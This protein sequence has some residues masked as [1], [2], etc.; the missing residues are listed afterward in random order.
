ME[1]VVFVRRRLSC[2]KAWLPQRPRR[3]LVRGGGGQKGMHL[4]V[5]LPPLLCACPLLGGRSLGFVPRS[6]GSV[7][8]CSLVTFGAR[9]QP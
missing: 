8:L 2:M 3:L 7:R 9:G 1:V 6:I 4:H 5:H